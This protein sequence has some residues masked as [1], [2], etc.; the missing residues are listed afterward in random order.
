MPRIL[1]RYVLGNRLFLLFCFQCFFLTMTCLFRVDN[2]V[3]PFIVCFLL[4]WDLV[5]PVKCNNSLLCHILI[6]CFHKNDAGWIATG[7]IGCINCYWGTLIDLMFWASVLSLILHDEASMPGLTIWSIP[8][9]NFW[10]RWEHTLL[11]CRNRVNFVWQAQLHRYIT[12]T[13]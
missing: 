6:D 8:H 7:C 13:F 1:N 10:T 5:I 3:S 9:F 4:I 11:M 2:L 12:W